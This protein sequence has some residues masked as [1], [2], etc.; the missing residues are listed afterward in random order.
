LGTHV[1]TQEKMQAA[2]DE[3]F[4]LVGKKKISI[5]IGQRFPLESAGDAQEALAGRR[6][7]GATILTLD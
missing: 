6:T 1:A 4:S 5:A 2:A 3:L 7:P